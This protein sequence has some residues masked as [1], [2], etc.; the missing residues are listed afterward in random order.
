MKLTTTKI[1]V[2]VL[3]LMLFQSGYGVSD[4]FEKA[5][6]ALNAGERAEA[7]AIVQKAHP[8]KLVGGE[9]SNAD[10]VQCDGVWSKN[11][12]DA[13]EEVLPSYYYT[14]LL[15]EET[16]DEIEE[17]LNEKGEALRDAIIHLDDDYKIIDGGEYYDRF[18]KYGEESDYI[19][20]DTVKDAFLDAIVANVY[21]KNFNNDTPL[22]PAKIMNEGQ[23]SAWLLPDNHLLAAYV[24]PTEDDK[25][26]N[27]KKGV[28]AWAGRIAEKWNPEEEAEN[29]N[30][31]ER[32]EGEDEETDPCVIDLRNS[33]NLEDPE[34]PEET[35]DLTAVYTAIETEAAAAHSAVS[36]E[37]VGDAARTAA[38]EALANKLKGELENVLIGEMNPE[39]IN[40]SDPRISP[41]SNYLA[42]SLNRAIYE[43]SKTVKP[44]YYGST[45][46][47]LTYDPLKAILEVF[48]KQGQVQDPLN[49]AIN[50]VIVDDLAWLL[51]QDKKS[52]TTVNALDEAVIDGR[53]VNPTKVFETLKAEAQPFDDETADTVVENLQLIKDNW[54][55]QNSDSETEENSQPEQEPEQDDPQNP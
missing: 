40:D 46:P 11:V 38:V 30:L 4:W 5:S 31:L 32:Y 17:I 51:R 28:L 54:V 16:E 3:M 8:E 33:I 13:I 49:K 20:A 45:E 29:K 41:L 9:L 7:Y 39:D 1:S 19:N 2:P 48:D 44:Y 24:A 6:I 21:N 12:S 53:E 25:T 23:S 43:N 52:T 14:N 47:S 18:I 50:N 35:G 55:E 26:E 27:A 37:E 10:K 22:D 36:N 34:N 15:T 42:V